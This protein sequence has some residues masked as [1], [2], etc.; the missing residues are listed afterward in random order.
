M[1]DTCGPKCHYT[2]VKVRGQRARACSF[3]LPR[4]VQRLN[5]QYQGWQHTPFLHTRFLLSSSTSSCLPPPVYIH[6]IHNYVLCYRNCSVV[7]LQRT[8]WP[9]R[10]RSSLL[11]FRRGSLFVRACLCC[12]VSLLSLYY[13]IIWLSVVPRCPERLTVIGFTFVIW[14]NSWWCYSVLYKRKY[15]TFF[16]F[17]LRW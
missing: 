11:F 15:L 4:G 1:C 10:L 13:V 5:F 3:L 16:V 12:S 9:Q 7:H 6:V 2:L 8:E 14:D 17:L